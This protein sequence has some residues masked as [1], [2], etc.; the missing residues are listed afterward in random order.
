MTSAAGVHEERPGPHRVQERPVDDAVGLVRERE[1][2]DD[3]LGLPRQRV[4]PDIGCTP[5]RA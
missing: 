1:E 5:G 2:D 4:R 3:D